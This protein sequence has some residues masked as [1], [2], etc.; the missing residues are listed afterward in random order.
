MKNY[1]HTRFAHFAMSISRL[2]L[3][4]AI[5]VLV[6]LAGTW[7]GMAN[8]FAWDIVFAIILASVLFAAL[9]WVLGF[10][11][12][13]KAPRVEASK[14]EVKTPMPEPEKEAKPSRSPFDI[15]LDD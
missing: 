7:V 12:N 6:F 11:A 10:S 5:I 1:H 9:F 15:P 4:F 13:Q 14:S 2:L 3:V 8:N